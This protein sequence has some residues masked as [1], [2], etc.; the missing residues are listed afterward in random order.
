MSTERRNRVCLLAGL[1]L[2]VAAILAIVFAATPSEAGAVVLVLAA[3]LLI[4]RVL[5]GLGVSPLVRLIFSARQGGWVAVAFALLGSSLLYGERLG[6]PVVIGMEVVAIAVLAYA[7]RC[8]AGP[9]AGSASSPWAPRP[10]RA[11]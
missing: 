7:L 5:V 1:V 6:T 4:N 3:V 8:G 9:R 10:R 11:V 2:G